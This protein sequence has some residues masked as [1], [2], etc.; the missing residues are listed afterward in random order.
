M[1][2]KSSKS[3]EKKECLMIPRRILLV[4]GYI[5]E[6][7]KDIVQELIQE[8]FRFYPENELKWDTQSNNAGYYICS[9]SNDLK[10]IK[11]ITTHHSCST[12]LVDT[13][14]KDKMCKKFDIEFIIE[15]Q[16]DGFVVIIGYVS[17]I[18]DVKSWEARLG[19]DENEYICWYMIKRIVYNKR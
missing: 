10:T 12:W 13:I 7:C 3:S 11:D 9:F 1:G 15:H 6:N 4:A 8:I 2:N 18:Q 14:I 5:R 17:S 16:G 19:L